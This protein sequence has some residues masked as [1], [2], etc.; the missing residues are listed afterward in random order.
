[1]FPTQCGP[2]CRPL[3]AAQTLPLTQ[4]S[5]GCRLPTAALQTQRHLRPRRRRRRA[6][7]SQAQAVRRQGGSTAG[8]CSAFLWNY[9]QVRPCSG[10]ANLCLQYEAA[11]CDNIVLSVLSLLPNPV[12]VMD[13]QVPS[14]NT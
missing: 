1:M 3:V 8:A 7:P 9:M 14:S 10:A 11:S 4:H 5:T 6:V 2:I 13:A 12:L